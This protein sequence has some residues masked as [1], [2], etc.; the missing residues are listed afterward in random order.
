MEIVDFRLRI[1]TENL[2][3]KIILS[4]YYAIASFPPAITASSEHNKNCTHLNSQ[5]E[6]ARIFLLFYLEFPESKK[7]E[8]FRERTGC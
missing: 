2:Q 8:S 7:Q 4:G 1:G 6:N 3:F 5:P